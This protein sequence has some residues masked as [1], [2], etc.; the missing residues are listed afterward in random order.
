MAATLIKKNHTKRH[1]R[2]NKMAEIN[3][4]PFVDV[5]LVLLIIFMVAA[6]L[7]TTG[8]PIDLPKTSGIATIKGS[9]KSLDIS[10]DANGNIYI[11]KE[12]LNVSELLI[13][14]NAIASEN[15]EIKV[16]ISGDAYTNYGRII[17]VMAELKKAGFNKVG[18]KTQ[19]TNKNNGK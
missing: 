4:T 19:N 1:K 2:H 3:V 16:I 7:L 12:V 11:G 6:P 9:D 15:N 14:L 10:I 17:E 18:L 13:H 5:M 8:I